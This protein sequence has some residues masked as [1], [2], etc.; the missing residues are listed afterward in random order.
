M[1]NVELEDSDLDLQPSPYDCE[2]LGLIQLELKMV[3]LKQSVKERIITLD[4]LEVLFSYI[5]Q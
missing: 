5:F 3:E 1:R 2:G 4:N